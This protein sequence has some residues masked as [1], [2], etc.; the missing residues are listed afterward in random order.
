MQRARVD[1]PQPDSPT[2]PNV[3]PRRTSNETPSTARSVPNVFRTWSTKRSASAE[4]SRTPG[5]TLTPPPP[6]RPAG[7]GARRASAP[8]RNGT[9]PRRMPRRCQCSRA[10][11][12]RTG[13]P[14]ARARPGSAARTGS[15]EAG[16]R[17]S[18]GSP[19]S[20]AAARAAAGRA[21]APSA[22]GP[23]C[24]GASG[25]ANSSS[26]GARSTKRP[27]Y[28]TQRAVA[29]VGDDAEVVR[30]Q[31]HRRAVLAHE[32]VEQ[33]E[34]LRLRRHVE[35]GGRL[36]GDQHGRVVRDRDRD[37]DALAHAAR[38]LVRVV[39]Q[40]AVGLRDL[41]VPQQVDR[42]ALARPSP[43]RGRCALDRLDHLRADRLDRVERAHRVLEERARC[44]CRGRACSWRSDSCEMSRPR[45]RPG[46]R[47]PSRAARSARGSRARA[48]TCPS[49]TRRR[50][51]AGRAQLEAHVA[52][53]AH[54]PHAVLERC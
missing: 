51:D 24:T 40:A 49:R 33:R 18:A 32:A 9:R 20:W 2:R 39:V 47:A 53:G 27:A 16:S 6:P 30:D 5:M 35:R 41:D 48:P 29:E 23:R 26:T 45:A 3:S 8:R 31:D 37:R 12:P 25:R 15:Q 46:R 4:P 21:A 44:P 1:F 22:A 36:V 38:V 43:E 11:A 54:R 13:R 42:R 19:G 7:R 28:M 14:R 52:H 17:G 10:P 50:P 34:H